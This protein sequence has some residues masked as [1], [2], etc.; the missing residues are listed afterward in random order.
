MRIL[1][2]EAEGVKYDILT[3]TLVKRSSQHARSKSQLRYVRGIREHEVLPLNK[4][5]H[6][7]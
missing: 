2:V 3:E 7:Q 1:T 4:R 5:A 6:H